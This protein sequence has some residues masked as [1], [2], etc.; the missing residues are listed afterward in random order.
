MKLKTLNLGS[1]F[2]GQKGRF[3]YY[4][5][6]GGFKSILLKLKHLKDLEELIIEGNTLGY[7]QEYE[8]LYTPLY[9]L[10]NLIMIDFNEIGIKDKGVEELGK[11]MKK[12]LDFLEILKLDGNEI[13]GEGFSKLNFS[14][15]KRLKVLS[16]SNNKIDDKHL[17]VFESINYGSLERL[18]IANNEIKAISVKLIIEKIVNSNNINKIKELN[19]SNNQIDENQIR[20]GSNIPL[21]EENFKSLDSNDESKCSG[22]KSILDNLHKMKDLKIVNFSSNNLSN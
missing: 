19:F 7:E 18:L 15:Q 17:N 10:K 2:I 16:L 9:S 6:I 13:T 11:I 8:L 3:I 22:L 5:G 1:N 20:N 12:S 14:K 4:I 21:N